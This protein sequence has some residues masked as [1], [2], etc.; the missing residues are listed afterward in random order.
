M[1]LS[2]C[3]L[4]ALQLACGLCMQ[5]LT[6]LL[7]LVLA[8]AGLVLHVNAEPADLI[9]KVDPSSCKP[10]DSSAS[11]SFSTSLYG[12]CGDSTCLV[13]TKTGRRPDCKPGTR[14]SCCVELSQINILEIQ[15][16]I[17]NGDAW[18]N[19]PSCR[20]RDASGTCDSSGANPKELYACCD[21]TVCVASLDVPKELFV[22]GQPP[23]CKSMIRKACC[24][25]DIVAKI[26]ATHDTPGSG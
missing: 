19:G 20:T 7:L 22:N 5:V 18:I 25:F 16:K 11:C 10:R 14:Q 15:D 12:C 13:A 1:L 8:A 23:G 2:L 26:R 17:I 4:P 24:P 9:V 6:G 21:S 3:S